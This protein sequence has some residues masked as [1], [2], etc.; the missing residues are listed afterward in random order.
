M[1]Q[2]ENKKATS[3]V[4]QNQ[5]TIAETLR[6]AMKKAGKTD[7]QI[8]KMF[9]R[10]VG[11]NGEILGTK[12]TLT[13][14]IEVVSEVINGNS[15]VYFALNTEQGKKLSLQSIM[16]L[17]SLSGYVFD[18]EAE[19]QFYNDTDDD[20]NPIIESKTFKS[21]VH[22]NYCKSVTENKVTSQVANVEKIEKELPKL[23]TRNLVE[24]A[25][26]ISNDPELL[27][28]VELT[29]I[30]KTIRPY[31]AKKDS[32]ETVSVDMWLKGYKRVMVSQLWA[33]TFPTKEAE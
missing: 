26:I 21:E 6:V 17:S 4:A 18:V 2:D 19:Q 7:E 14:E 20:N 15:S 9:N 8:E 32:P 31:T 25:T 1:K 12:Y 10:N 11:T 23:P 27:Q 3:A 28:G 16:G 24:L 30:G 29:Y 22:T 33:W 5:T 13:G